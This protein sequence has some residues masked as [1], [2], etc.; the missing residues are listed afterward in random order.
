MVCTMINGQPN[1]SVQVTLLARARR[2][3][4]VASGPNATVGAQRVAAAR[5]G[6]WDPD[7]KEA[8]TAQQARQSTR[9][10]AVGDAHLGPPG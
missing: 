1:R 7:S 6:E 9:T 3:R 2:R 4:Q 8:A 10:W 5:S